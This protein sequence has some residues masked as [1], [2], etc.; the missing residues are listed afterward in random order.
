[1]IEARRPDTVVVDK[2]KKETMIIDVTIPGDRKGCD[3]E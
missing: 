1:M 2:V 3:K